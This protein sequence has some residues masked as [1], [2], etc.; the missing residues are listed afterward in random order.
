M[1][2]ASVLGRAAK[3]V[4]V[5]LGVVDNPVAVAILSVVVEPEHGGRHLL[6]CGAG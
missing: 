3:H 6:V 5:D 1:A 2:P 4:Q